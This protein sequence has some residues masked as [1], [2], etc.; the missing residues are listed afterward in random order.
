MK[1]NAA[2]HEVWIARNKCFN[3]PKRPNW[4]LPTI[5]TVVIDALLRKPAMTAPNPGECEVVAEDRG[6]HQTCK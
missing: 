1:M 3:G 4:R 5:H 6:A 2:I